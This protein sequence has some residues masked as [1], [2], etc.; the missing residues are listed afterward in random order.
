[1]KSQA[2]HDLRHANISGWT[3]RSFIRSMQDALPYHNNANILRVRNLLDYVLSEKLIN[4]N[5]ASRIL[6]VKKLF[7]T[8]VPEC[9]AMELVLL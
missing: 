3:V 8:L 9:I 7:L 2:G 5:L 6:V 1:M 4:L